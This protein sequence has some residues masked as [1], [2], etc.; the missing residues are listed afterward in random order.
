MFFK[1]TIAFSF[2]FGDTVYLI[3]KTDKYFRKKW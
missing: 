3:S 2:Y 1:G